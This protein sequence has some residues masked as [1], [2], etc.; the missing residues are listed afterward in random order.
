MI[1]GLFKKHCPVC[2]Q[3]VEKEKAVKRF[4]KYLCSDEHAEEYRKIFAKEESRSAGHGGC[5]GKKI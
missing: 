3:T 4:G 5:C 1:L 2:E